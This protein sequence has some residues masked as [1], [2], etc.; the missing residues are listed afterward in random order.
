MLNTEQK[1]M[2]T[3]SSEMSI[4]LLKHWHKNVNLS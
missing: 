3:T 4:K 2:L 1:W